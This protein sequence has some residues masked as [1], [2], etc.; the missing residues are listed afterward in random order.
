MARL[1]HVAI[2]IET[3]RGYGRGLLRG[4]A[5]YVREHGPWSVYF[6][7]H[8][9]GAPPPPWLARWRGNGIL[10]RIDTRSL[11]R[12]VSQT[13]RRVVDLR[14]ALA[15]LRFP[16]VGPDNRAIARLIREHFVQSNFRHLAFCGAPRREVAGVLFG[17]AMGHTTGSYGGRVRAFLSTV[18]SDVERMDPRPAM[19]AGQPVPQHGSHHVSTSPAM[20][21]AIRPPRPP[22]RRSECPRA[23]RRPPHRRRPPWP[24]PSWILRPPRPARPPSR[25]RA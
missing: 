17:A 19:I 3:S 23:R 9:L 25:R 24:R 22:P 14:N 12:A 4:V 13:R 6:R 8:A 2:L 15:G 7:P 20:V 1:P 16:G 5:C 10:A 18:V 11:A 21:A